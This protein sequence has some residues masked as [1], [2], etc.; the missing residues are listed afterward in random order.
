MDL[1]SLQ[2][3]GGRNWSFPCGWQNVHVQSI[4]FCRKLTANRSIL[5]DQLY[6]TVLQTFFAFIFFNPHNVSYSGS[7][8]SSAS[9]AFH[10]RLLA[11]TDDKTTDVLRIQEQ[12]IVQITCV[13]VKGYSPVVESRHFW[14]RSN[15]TTQNYV[16]LVNK[17]RQLQTNVKF[18]GIHHFLCGPGSS[19]GIATV[20]G[21]DGPGIEFRWGR[22]FSQT[23]R[24][25]LWPTQPPVQWVQGISRG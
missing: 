24:P 21:L 16:N 12:K 11:V 8:H 23:S 1:S 18:V 3:R 2:C 7:L 13:R 6:D 25:A 20:Y 15:R 14:S 10:M 17:Y 22:D 19:V 4:S 9:F 5:F